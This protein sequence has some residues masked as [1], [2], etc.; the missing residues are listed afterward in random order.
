LEAGAP[1]LDGL[2][3]RGVGAHTREEAFRLDAL[4][5]TA[6]LLA[7]LLVALGDAPDDGLADLSRAVRVPACA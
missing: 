6:G 4:D 1:T 5:P 2:G 7:G 3:L